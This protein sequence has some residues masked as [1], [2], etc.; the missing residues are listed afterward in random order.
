MSCSHILVKCIDS[1]GSGHL[2]IL[3]VHVVCARSRIITYP[4]AKVLDFKRTLLVDL[5]GF[6]QLVVFLSRCGSA[7]A[8][9]S[10]V[11]MTRYTSF[12]LTI[13]PLA[14]LTFLSFVRK[15]QKRDLATTLLGANMRIR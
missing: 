2:T 3:L 9:L 12:K 13:S 4:D 7:K 14:F 8:M 5:H 15:Y 1:F 11:K 10:Q 6:M